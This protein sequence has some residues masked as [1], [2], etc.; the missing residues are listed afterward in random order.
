MSLESKT[1]PSASETNNDHRNQ[2]LTPQ[3]T[4]NNFFFSGSGAI[5][6]EVGDELVDG[7]LCSWW[8]VWWC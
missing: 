3:S 8:F 4:L 7:D 1:K 2:T 5:V 6:M